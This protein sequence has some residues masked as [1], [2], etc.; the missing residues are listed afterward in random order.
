MKED[1]NPKNGI[2]TNDGVGDASAAREDMK[3]I[4]IFAYELEDTGS[5][6]PEEAERVAR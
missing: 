1:A 6:T 3:S 2:R 5:Y 4:G